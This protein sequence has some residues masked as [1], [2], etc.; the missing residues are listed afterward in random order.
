MKRLI[1][2]LMVLITCFSCGCAFA[3]DIESGVHTENVEVVT[4]TPKPE[5]AV[6]IKSSLE[7]L[8][9]VLEGTEVTLT[10]V[11]HNFRDEDI[12][13]ITWQEQRDG[14]W[15]DVGSG[16]TYKFNINT[17]NV[18]YAWRVKIHIETE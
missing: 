10:A 11:L 17:T 4:P 9:Q 1:A 16:L 5:W 12:Y 18:H 6:T 14:Q 13:T 2:I 15:Y 7:G 8:T 3:E